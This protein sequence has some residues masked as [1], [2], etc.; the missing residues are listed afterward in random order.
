MCLFF[1]GF[2]FSIPPLV[3]RIGRIFFY[4]HEREKL[5]DRVEGWIFS[6]H[7]GEGARSVCQVEEWVESHE[8]GSWICDCG[9]RSVV[10]PGFDENRKILASGGRGKEVQC[11][12]QREGAF[13]YCRQ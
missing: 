3:N 11:R 2:V 4:L 8:F 5:R 1:S 13:S 10:G 7:E 12:N 6:C 9:L